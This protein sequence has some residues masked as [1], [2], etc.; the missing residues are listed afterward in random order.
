VETAL[1]VVQVVV[2]VLYAGL[3]LACLRLWRRERGPAARWAVAAFGDLGLTIA[4]GFVTPDPDRGWWALLLVK[5][6]ILGLVLFPYLLYRFMTVFSPAGRALERFATTLTALLAVWTLALPGLPEDDESWSAFFAAY[7]VVFLA[8]WTIFSV[9]AA[10]RLWRAGS[11]HPTVA[12]RRMRLL[13]IAAL[14]LTLALI[15]TAFVG[16]D[17]AGLVIQLLAIASALLFFAGVAPP[18]WLRAIWR[19]PEQERLR[20]ATMALLRG[21]T[22]E[23]ISRNLLPPAASVVGAR[24]AALVA[25]DGTVLSSHGGAAPDR[26]PI[27][28]DFPLASL[29]V[30]TSPQTPFFGPD[31]LGMLRSLGNFIELALERSDLLARERETVERLQELDELKNTFLSAV[32]HELRTPLAVILGMA[33]TL[34]Q[35]EPRLDDERRRQ[36]LDHLVDASRKLESLLADLLDLDRLTRGVLQPR[37]EQTDLAELVGRVV[38]GI[39]GDASVATEPLTAAVDAAKVERIVE[40]LLYNAYKHTPPGSKV[41]V[42]LD[43][44]EEGALLVV[45]DAGPGIPPALRES[46]FDPFQR[47]EATDASGTGIG[48]SLVARFA[49]LHGGRAW[50]EERAGGG[51]SFRVFLPSAE[52]IAGDAQADVTVTR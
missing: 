49:E 14:G 42:R 25:A 30:W 48:L 24:Q 6:D 11:G 21:A 44:E 43:A 26:E 5:L 35:H 50:V 52:R 2:L 31:E 51:A 17:A 46:I 39:G 1:D 8:H 28:L 19:R 13:S 45:E 4:F 10:A 41:W 47:G 37:L 22:R 9:V 20:E 12:R 7:V 32:S 3:A 34:Q 27:R 40:N 16:G 38:E 15:G 23:E 36:L 29:L 18:A 33:L